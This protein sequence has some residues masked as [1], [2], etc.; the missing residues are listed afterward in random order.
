[1]DDNLKSQPEVPVEKEE[2]SPLDRSIE[3]AFNIYNYQ[4]DPIL[5]S[6]IH[7]LNEILLARPAAIIL[8]SYFNSKSSIIKTL[9]IARSLVRLLESNSEVFEKIRVQLETQEN[10]NHLIFKE[11]QKQYIADIYKTIEEGLTAGMVEVNQICPKSLTLSEI[12]GEFDEKEMA[13]HEGMLPH[14]IRNAIDKADKKESWIVFDGELDKCWCDGLY[15]AL[16]DTRR[17]CL[18]NSESLILPKDLVLIFESDSLANAAPSTISR[19]GIFSVSQNDLSR[20]E[21]RRV[22]KE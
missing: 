20:S 9:S 15:S 2:K 7:Q 10:Y 6:K 11:V 21:E 14:C 13:W 19:C 8:G 22:G 12:Y 4:P 3:I 5:L 17:L 16:D 1:M 18:P